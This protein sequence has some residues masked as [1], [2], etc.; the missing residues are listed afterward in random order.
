MSALGVLLAYVLI[1]GVL[2]AFLVKS[3]TKHRLADSRIL[4]R[5]VNW[6]KINH[7]SSAVYECEVYPQHPLMQ[8]IRNLI[9]CAEFSPY[10]FYIRLQLARREVYRALDWFSNRVLGYLIAI[11][12]ITMAYV[13]IL[14]QLYGFGYLSTHYQWVIAVFEVVLLYM[15]WEDSN[16][17]KKWKR[18]LDQVAF[19]LEAHIVHD[20]GQ[21]FP[22]A[23]TLTDDEISVQLKRLTAFEAEMEALETEGIE[24]YPNAL[25][26]LEL[27]GYGLMK[28]EV[29]A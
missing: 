27:D 16:R 17:K 22:I 4:V 13:I 29:E 28:G 9:H 6:I 15:A 11:F 21:T 2:I 14:D 20:G 24:F 5:V 19:D 1:S 18:C 10:G 8:G 7:L 25:F 12:L 23:R 3:Y 26:P